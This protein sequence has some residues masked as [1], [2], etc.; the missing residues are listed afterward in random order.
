MKRPVRSSLAAAGILAL[1]VLSTSPSI[2][3][4][5]PDPKDQSHAQRFVQPSQEKFAEASNAIV[6]RG[7]ADPEYA[8]L[9]ADNKTHSVIIYR[10][11]GSRVPFYAAVIGKLPTGMRVEFR[12]APMSAAEAD[13]LVEDIWSKR[14]V[15]A[16]QGID[17][18]AVFRDA[19]GHVGVHVKTLTPRIERLL[20][21]RFDRYGDGSVLV[22]QGDPIHVASRFDDTAPFYGG[23]RIN[24]AN[25][26]FKNGAVGHSICT[27]GFGGKSL[28]NNRRYVITAFHCVQPGD[29]R[30]WTAGG[31]LIGSASDLDSGHDLAFVPVSGTLPW[32]WVGP[33]TPISSEFTKRVTDVKK[34]VVG[35]HIC[36]SGSFSGARCYATVI[37]SGHYTLSTDW[38]GQGS[39]DAY[40]YIADGDNGTE[41][42]AEGDSGGPVLITHGDTVTAVG[43]ISALGTG[44]L[45]SCV[46]DGTVCSSRVYFADIY[47]EAVEHQLDLTS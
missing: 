42:V 15:F 10:K 44:Q 23:N 14:D 41:M 34:P 13:G 32:V 19:T 9:T 17:I 45:V 24:S 5:K 6:Q 8:G 29:P 2:A 39:Y 30:F 40:L 18:T 33:L 38:A 46:G 16:S 20:K 22:G 27:S 11:G 35:D 25:G 7:V 21:N 43:I 12:K 28:A 47:T 26:T 1:A 36:T 31:T 37:N 4:A 3:Y